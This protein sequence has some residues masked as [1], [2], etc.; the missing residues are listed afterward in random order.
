VGERLIQH[1]VKPSAVLDL[2]L[3]PEYYFSY[4]T[5]VAV[6]FWSFFWPLLVIQKCYARDKQCYIKDCYRIDV[7]EAQW[8]IIVVEIMS[9]ACGVDMW[10][11]V[12]SEFGLVDIVIGNYFHSHLGNLNY[13]NC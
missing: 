12:V 2:W 9:F 11:I 6:H 7:T 1:E 13:D 3:T 8:L 10:T 4:C 5:S